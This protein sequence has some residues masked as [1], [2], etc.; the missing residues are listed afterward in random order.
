MSFSYKYSIWAIDVEIEAEVEKEEKEEKEN[1][2]IT[3]VIPF[4]ALKCLR[5]LKMI[6]LKQ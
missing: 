2:L 3:K 5:Q 6:T 1:T 4:I